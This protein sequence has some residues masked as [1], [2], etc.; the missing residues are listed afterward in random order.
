MADLE[1]TFVDM[2]EAS[3]GITA[4]VGSGVD[5]RIY[6]LLVPEDFSNYPA[7]T[8]QVVSETR[9]PELTKQNGL[10]RARVQT[11]CWARSYAEAK[12]LKE[13]VRNAIDGGTAFFTNGVFIDDGQD[14]VEPSPD[15][16]PARLYCK[17]VDV[18]VWVTET[19]PTF[20]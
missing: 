6:P 16:R 14:S 12:T 9:E 1:A 2:L 20:A 3:A 19:D 13:A 8:F 10:M 17:R 18:L 15:A 7:I 4:I 11:N 5:A